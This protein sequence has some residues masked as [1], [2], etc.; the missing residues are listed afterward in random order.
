MITGELPPIDDME[1][2]GIPVPDF[3][4][5]FIERFGEDA[6]VDFCLKHGGAR[7]D[8]LGMTR[9]LSRRFGSEVAA[10]IH[11]TYHGHRFYAPMWLKSAWVIR[12]YHIRR[13]I[14]DG[15]KDAVICDRLQCHPRTVTR[16]RAYM[17]ERHLVNYSQAEDGAAR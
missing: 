4:T 3:F 15:H 9:A 1:A 5:R 12:R 17:R 11:Q 10:W 8:T 6:A 7:I 14:R 13:L 2:L 16:Q